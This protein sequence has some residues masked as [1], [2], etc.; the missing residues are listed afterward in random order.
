MASY[1][2][3]PED[4]LTLIFGFHV[5]GQYLYPAKEGAARRL[6]TVEE[7]AMWAALMYQAGRT[8][9]PPGDEDR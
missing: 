1:S 8:N 2:E 4:L 6:A 7:K 5:I 9:Q 3:Y